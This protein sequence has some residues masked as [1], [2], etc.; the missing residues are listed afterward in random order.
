MLKPKLTFTLFEDNGHRFYYGKIKNEVKV[1]AGI[2]TLLS[3]TVKSEFLDKWKLENN[4]NGKLEWSAKYGSGVH[5]ATYLFD[6]KQTDTLWDSFIPK[7]PEFEKEKTL[8]ELTSWHNFRKKYNLSL[9][10]AEVPLYGNIEGCEYITTLDRIFLCRRQQITVTEEP[11]GEVYQKNGKGYKKGDLK[12]D[13]EGKPLTKKVENIEEVREVWIVDLKSNPFDKDQK[14][15]YD[16]HL[17]QLMAQKAAYHQNFKIP[18]LPT[19]VRIFN[20]SATDW[21]E[22]NGDN[23]FTLTEW[24]KDDYEKREWNTKNYTQQDQSLFYHYL[25]IAMLKGYNKP[26]G[27]LREWYR[28]ELGKEGVTNKKMSYQEWAEKKF[29]SLIWHHH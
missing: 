18:S 19:K 21:R 9:L 26:E 13:K 27:A 25:Q 12:L 6:T 1:L 4:G 3:K 8:R 5:W 24:R 23:T 17:Y 2:T 28:F 16:T 20:W 7:L 29:M 14:E 10:L 11:A 22:D 15:Y